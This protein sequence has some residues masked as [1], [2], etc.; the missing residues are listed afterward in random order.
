M[1]DERGVQRMITL[2]EAEAVKIGFF[3]V[4]E[5]DYSRIFQALDSLTGTAAG[6]L[7]KNEEAEYSENYSFN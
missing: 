4:E 5:K 2:N 1:T 3:A 6:F 7:S